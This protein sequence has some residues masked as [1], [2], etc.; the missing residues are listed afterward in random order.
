[1]ERKKVVFI[2]GP[3]TGR[4]K[5][6]E[7]FGMVAELL[8][9]RGYI[10]LNPATLPGG[11]DNSQ[12]LRI[13]LAMLDSADAVLFLPGWEN[14]RGATIEYMH[15]QYADKPFAHTTDGLELVLR[16]SK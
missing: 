1:M 11:M 6:R 14:S 8:E 7:T 9:D 16:R 2:S 4:P 13:T 3:I 15:A 12:Y 10:P 5:Y